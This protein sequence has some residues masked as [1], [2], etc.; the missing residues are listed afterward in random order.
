MPPENKQRTNIQPKKLEQTEDPQV[1]ESTEPVLVDVKLS[2][3]LT[4]L[5]FSRNDVIPIVMGAAPEDYRRA[6]PPNSFI[7]VDDFQSVEQLAEYLHR[8]DKDDK[9]YNQYFAWK[10]SVCLHLVSVP[11]MEL[12]INAYRRQTDRHT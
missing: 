12:F 1:L 10:G 8:L 7:H 5:T 3:R 11:C 4:L 9:L 2:A 6:A